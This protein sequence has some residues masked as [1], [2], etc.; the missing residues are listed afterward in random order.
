MCNRE[1]DAIDWKRRFPSI[2]AIVSD[3]ALRQAVRNDT[4][5]ND[6]NAPLTFLSCLLIGDIP[7]SFPAAQT[8]KALNANLEVLNVPGMIRQPRRLCDKLLNPPQFLNTFAEIALARALLSR[9]FSVRL[10]E[11]FF[12][13]RDADLL[14]ELKGET[15]YVEVTNLA[16]RPIES[17]RVFA[18]DVANVTD[19]D[20]IF[21]KISTKF[22]EKFEEPQSQGWSGSAWV[23]IDV[24]KYDQQNLNA[25]FQSLFRPYWKDELSEL[26][27]ERCP[28][29]SGAIV[30]RSYPSSEEV[31]LVECIKLGSGLTI[32]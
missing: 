20:V 14:V 13:Q 5:A 30:F 31:E 26:L 24:A 12:E 1:A 15:A 16:S 22:R 32:K 17:G 8:L 23:A 25:V 18:G 4:Y 7:E 29:L 9:G 19:R 28:G 6:V 21:R 27:L 10:E 2:D 11:K 3:A